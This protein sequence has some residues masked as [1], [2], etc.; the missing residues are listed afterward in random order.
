MCL[1]PAYGY[2]LSVA[3]KADLEQHI[4][5]EHGESKE[6]GDEGKETFHSWKTYST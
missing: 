4:L 3:D 5:S 1:S 6:Q 2:Y